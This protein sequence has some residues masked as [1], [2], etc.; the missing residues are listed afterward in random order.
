MK[1]SF[2]M[3]LA[4]LWS[5]SSLIGQQFHYWESFTDSI[6][7]GVSGPG[8]IVDTLG[9]SWFIDFSN[10]NLTAPSDYFRVN[11]NHQFEAKDVDGEVIWFSPWIDISGD[12]LSTVAIQLF[13][14]GNLASTEYIK[15][16]YQTNSI[17]HPFN[18]NG[19]YSNDFD[20]IQCWMDSIPGDSIQIQVQVYNNAGTKS[21]TFDDLRVFSTISCLENVELI[22]DT[23]AIHIQ[24]DSSILNSKKMVLVSNSKPILDE[25]PLTPGLQINDS[26]FGGNLIYFDSLNQFT[27]LNP[28][29]GRTYYFSVFQLLDSVWSRGV[30]DSLFFNPPLSGTIQITEFA[31]HPTIPEY[32]FL[33]IHN[34]TDTNINLDGARLIIRNASSISK[35]IDFRKDWEPSLII[36]ANGFLILN[37]NRSKNLFQNEWAVDFDSLQS[38]VNYYRT[39]EN[40]LGN[41]HLF[42]I[43]MGGDSNLANGL[44]ITSSSLRPLTGERYVRLP[45]SMETI[46]ESQFASPGFFHTH[47]NEESLFFVFRNGKWLS[48]DST[49]IP[50]PDSTTGSYNAIIADTSATFSHDAKLNGLTILPKMGI[51]LQNQLITINSY[52]SF[53]NNATLSI[54]GNGNVFCLGLTN[55]KKSGSSSSLDYSAWSS[56]FYD[57]LIIA[58]THES[59]NPCD[60]YCFEASSQSFKYDQL[61]GPVFSCNGNLINF[62]SS[63]CITP[64]DGVSDGKFDMGR[65]YFIP[66]A[67]DSIIQFSVNQGTFNNGNISIPIYGSN[68]DSIT[69]SNDWNFVGNPYPSSINASALIDTNLG[70]ITNAIYLYQPTG[71]SSN[72]QYL[73]FNNTDD[74]QISSCQAFFVDANTLDTGQVGNL[75][76]SNAMR[77]SNSATF[78]KQK[79]ANEINLTLTGSQGS[80]YARIYLCS[81]CELGFDSLFDARKMMNQKLNIAT[82][83][84]NQKLVF[85]G[86]PDSTLSIPLFISMD[87]SGQFELQMA[88][89]EINTLYLEDKLFHTFHNLNMNPYTF[90]AAS[91]EYPD[92]FV[93]HLKS[94][95][96]TVL[97]PQNDE[98][99][100]IFWNANHLKINSLKGIINR[101]RIL[102][103]TGTSVTN[104]TVNSTSVSTT[105]N[106]EK[107]GIYILEVL[108]ENGQKHFRKSIFISPD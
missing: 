14:T 90:N 101:F 63:H 79:N 47:E 86:I 61:I 102:S 45:F 12:S 11:S 107:S 40:K 17:V 13:E 106:I 59:A 77:N 25:I 60:A 83:A 74:L 36:P 84:G 93:L 62:D 44:T 32:G 33:E 34:A 96:M 50:Q 20:S 65:G 29:K 66:G 37:R 108:M 15:L 53:E 21:H 31:R 88:S 5:Y 85:N 69:G 4:I 18:G 2:L 73:T 81:N 39:T 80:D 42:E 46:N 67:S 68:Q 58:N 35:I 55:F 92:R 105:T 70:L 103:I 100:R 30:Q 95:N 16:S 26:L 51:Q 41:Y 19:N 10:A 9:M 99:I 6:N 82:F 94:E 23:N 104:E 24:W 89:E 75:Q 78:F 87:Y 8:A 48:M 57:S 56:P 27:F 91:G 76:F 52:L 54:S 64:T 71:T 28:N 1:T 98:E 38:E 49:L 97:D 43:Q 7:K 72:S 3:L 22:Q